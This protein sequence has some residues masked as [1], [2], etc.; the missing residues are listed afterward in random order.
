MKVFL[1][2]NL[3]DFCENHYLMRRALFCVSF[4]F[5]FV[6]FWW[7]CDRRRSS[8]KTHSTH[9]NAVNITTEVFEQ[10]LHTAVVPVPHEDAVLLLSTIPSCPTHRYRLRIWFT[11]WGW[12]QWIIG[13]SIIL[14]TQRLLLSGQFSH[15]QIFPLQQGAE[16]FAARIDGTDNI[17][18]FFWLQTYI[19]KT[20]PRR[21]M[22]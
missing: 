2:I 10:H 5:L 6:I 11:V 3:T 20:N 1:D 12:L 17:L 13:I 7:M 21:I 8:Y 4:L 19:E 22:F 18:L 9:L 15:E 16:Q 14:T